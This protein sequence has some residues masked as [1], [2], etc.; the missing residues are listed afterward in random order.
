MDIKNRIKI[1]PVL[2]GDPR[3]DQIEILFK[4]LYKSESEFG[5]SVRLIEGGEKIWRR[6]IEKMLGKY[7]QI[8]V[9]AEEDKICGFSYGS[10]RMMPACF[11]GIVI[12]YWEAMIIKPEY[13]KLGL[14]DQMTLQLMDWWRE[15]GAVIFEGERLIT[16]YNAARNFDRLGFKQELIRYRRKA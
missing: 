8:I 2:P 12:G 13:R 14:G 7:A 11:G 6:T 3:L 10:L 15:K 5:V 4:Q 9:A 1:F 16:N